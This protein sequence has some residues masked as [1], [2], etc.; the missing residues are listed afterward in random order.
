[1]PIMTIT[2]RHCR[3][4]VTRKVRTKND[5]GHYCSRQ[6][7]D[8]DNAILKEERKAIR[9]IAKRLQRKVRKLKAEEARRDRELARKQYEEEARVCACKVCGVKFDQGSHLGAPRKYCPPCNEVILKEARKRQRRITRSKRRA[10]VRATKIEPIDPFEIFDRDNWHC[11]I[12]CKPTPKSK[13]GTLSDNAPELDHIVPL[14]KGGT[15][16]KDNVACACRKCNHEKSDEIYT[17]KLI[18]TA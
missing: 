4:S 7:S 16:T 3:E 18:K 12:C 8:A 15:H 14:S 6:C 2:C 13:R 9:A 17:E 1:M 11:Y 5:K 10:R